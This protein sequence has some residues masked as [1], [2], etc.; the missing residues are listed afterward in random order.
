MFSLKMN[1][2]RNTV[3]ALN[4]NTR[5]NTQVTETNLCFQ[6]ENHVNDEVKQTNVKLKCA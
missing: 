5:I 6:P 1:K 2:N 3:I 4:E